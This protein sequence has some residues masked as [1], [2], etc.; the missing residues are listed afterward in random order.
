VS[1]PASLTTRVFKGGFVTY[2]EG[3]AAKGTVRIVLKTPMIGPTDDLFVVPFDITIPLDENGRFAVI[4]PATNDPQWTPS[5]YQ[6]T[7]ITA[8]TKIGGRPLIRLGNM[9]APAIM[10]ATLQVPYNATTP[11]DA[12]DIFNVNPP[13]L[14]ETYVVLA[15]LG[16]PGGVATLGSDGKVLPGQLPTGSGGIVS[17]LDLTDKPD[18]FPPATHTHPTGE[19]TGLDAALI[20]KASNAALVDGLATKSNTNHTHA[21]SDVT[22]K[23][24]TY[25]H[26]P[27]EWDEIENKPDTFPGAGDGSGGIVDWANVQNKPLTFPHDEVTFSQVTGKPSTFPPSAHSHVTAEVT[28]LDTSLAAKATTSALTTGLAG[29]VDTATLSNYATTSSVATGLGAKADTTALTSGLAS[30]ADTSAVTTSLAG[31]ADLVAG[32]IPT[33]QIPSIA[34]IDF[35]GSV[36]TQSAMLALTGQKGDFAIRSDLGQEWIIT[37]SDPTQ[38]ASW[39]A[40]PTGTSAVQSVNSQTGTVVLGKTDVGLGSVDNTSDAG[41]PVSTAQSTALAL[42]APIASPTFTGTVSGVTAAMVGL[43]SVTN[44]ADSAKPVST[45]QQTALDLKAPLASPTFTGTVAGV[46]ATMVGLGSVNNTADSAKPVSTAQATA[47]ALKADLASPT[48][49]GVPAAP[50]AAAGTSTTQLATTAFVAALG[51]LKA[52]LAS[53]TFTG[54]VGG[55]SAAMVGLGSV[56]N[57]ADSAKPV[58]TAQ[59]AALDLKQSLSAL[60]TKGD[61]YVATAAGVVSRLAA[62]ANT[63]VLIADSTTATGL[64][65]GAA[66]GGGGGAT[67]P[68]FARAYV[69]AGDITPGAAASF[70]PIAGLSIAVPAVAGENVEVALSCLLNQT[71]SD[72]FDLVV[73]VAGAIVRYGSTGTSSPTAAGEGDP[74]MYPVNSGTIIRTT[75]IYSLAVASGDLSGGNVTFGLAFKGSGSGKVFASTNYPLRWRVRNDH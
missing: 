48:L 2:P 21:F 33:S 1:F 26:A 44:T 6:V 52:P 37:G 11:I 14:G 51:A 49:T 47:I 23:P 19:I 50:T 41:K 5:S 8:P 35:L 15:S 71:G 64:K 61:L 32:V 45:A 30:K 63:Q 36:A 18:T 12:T 17:W 75:S 56:T 29:K 4:L 57:T 16:V 39:T 42:K 69:T 67:A 28:G 40:M 27:I 13:T 31:K 46:T 73:L 62:G 3:A 20:A 74:S 59:Q 9:P 66:S 10:R 68:V 65:W 54:T 58:S 60:T 53:P 25:P 43:G 55:I 34:V 38:L 72:F 70:T 24:S 7:V 22:G